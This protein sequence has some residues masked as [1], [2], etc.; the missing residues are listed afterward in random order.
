MV[1][2][3]LNYTTRAAKLFP[4]FVLGTSAETMGA[5]MRNTQGSLFT[6]LRAGGRALE[7]EVAA[8]SALHGGFFTRTFKGL[9][10]APKDIAKAATEGIKVAKL[11]GK[12]ALAGGFKGALKGVGKK[13]PVV[14][15]VLTIALEAPNIFRAFKEGGLI[16]GLKEVAGAAVE[17][18]AMA[19][20]AAIGSAICPGIGTVVGGIIGGLVGMFVR[21]KS[22]SDKQDEINAVKEQLK[23]KCGLSDEEIKD[24]EEHK[25]DEKYIEQVL[26]EKA[27]RQLREAGL[28][29][30]QI[31]QIAKNGYKED[32]IA[33]VI[34]QNCVNQLKEAG[35]TDV[36]IEQIAKNGYKE[37]D[38][39]AAICENYNNELKAAGLTEAQISEIAAN[40]YQETDIQKAIDENN[41]IISR[42]QQAGVPYYQIQA[43][44]NN[45][46]NESEIESAIQQVQQRQCMYPNY[47]MYGFNTPYSTYDNSGL[48]SNSYYQYNLYN[49]QGYYTNPNFQYSGYGQMNGFSMAGDMFNSYLQYP[50]YN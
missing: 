20:G 48:Y 34:E 42:L 4:D 1:S 36:Q 2:G 12:S 29:D 11:S 46:F 26:K 25:F 44:A 3:L 49:N 19:G 37:E 47:P 10:S 40:G 43:I 6:K 39:E 31:E 15:A 24:I 28:T 5:A 50:M 38:I 16:A 30:E 7:T 14:G 35:L 21:G 41:K 9:A 45:G 32:E 23:T 18:G 27:D 13:L 17:L 33:S 8:N 22:H